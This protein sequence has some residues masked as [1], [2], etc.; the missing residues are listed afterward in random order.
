MYP[1]TFDANIFSL[2]LDPSRLPT[3]LTNCGE[4]YLLLSLMTSDIAGVIE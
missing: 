1:V 4:S 2:Q 3:R